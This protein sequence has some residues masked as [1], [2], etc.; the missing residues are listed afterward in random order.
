MIHFLD[1]KAINAQYQ[2]E[3]DAAIQSVMDSGW[4]IKGNAVSTFERNFATYCGTQHAIGVANGLDAL[5]L[6]FRALMLQGK[7]QKGDEV[8]VPANTYIASILALTQNGLTPILVEPDPISFNLSLKSTEKNISK[9]TKAILSVH[10]YGQLAEDLS[11]F[12]RDHQLLLVEDAAQAHGATDAHGKRAGNFGIAAGF[13]F[14]PGKNLGALGDAGAVTTNDSQLAN[15]ISQL[16]NYG[17]EKKYHNS[18]PGINSRLDEMQA[19][20]LDVK[21]KYLDQ[22]I[23]KRR[24][25]ASYYSENI[26][27]PKISLP[28]WE[29]TVSDHVF[30]LYVIRCREREALKDYLENHGIQTVIHYPIPPHKQEA[31]KEW[32]HLSFPLTE[33]IHKEVLS[34]PISPII[35]REEQKRVV[36]V[37]N[38]F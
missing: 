5:I 1:L 31:Y 24:A 23:E 8:L 20:I 21:L 36:E 27:N 11:E 6:I 9:K 30:H 32:N 38:L 35:T 29:A 33:Q 16:G 18:L 28:H 4:Y 25:V 19:A 7:L 13:S 34:I 37:L 3:I 12:C 2:T 10:L 22:E 14:Y 26:S 15:I 17:S